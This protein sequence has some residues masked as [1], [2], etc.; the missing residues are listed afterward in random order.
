MKS[1]VAS[2]RDN[3]ITRSSRRIHGRFSGFDF[4]LLFRN[5]CTV[6][7]YCH[8]KFNLTKYDKII[9]NP[10]SIPT[11][12]VAASASPRDIHNRAHAAFHLR[13]CYFKVLTVE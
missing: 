9:P 5:H 7:N 6:N 13:Q 3:R 8:N 4:N 10:L 1:A 11:R 12:R 2:A